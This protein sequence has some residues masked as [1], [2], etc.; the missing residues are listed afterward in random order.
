MRMR[1][2]YYHGNMHVRVLQIYTVIHAI[3]DHYDAYVYDAIKLRAM[4]PFPLF[5]KVPIAHE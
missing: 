3:V 1:M 2:S 4:N 5:K